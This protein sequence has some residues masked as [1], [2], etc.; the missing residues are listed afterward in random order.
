MAASATLRHRPP[1]PQKA[2]SIA[3]DPS[4]TPEAAL[5]RVVAACLAQLEANTPGARMP[6]ASDALDTPDTTGLAFRA[7]RAGNPDNAEYV[8]QMRVAVRRLRS[9]LRFFDV[10]AARSARK[11]FGATLRRLARTLGEQRNWDVFISTLLPRCGLPP[12]S[13]DVARRRALQLRGTAHERVC[14]RIKAPAHARLLHGLALWLSSLA[15]EQGAGGEGSTA[16]LRTPA[17]QPG[18]LAQVARKG[19]ARLQRRVQRGAK[20]FLTMP[21][22]ARHAVRIEVKRLR[23]AVDAT[24]ALF[25]ARAVKRYTAA[26][27]A[28]QQLLGDLTD[29]N[30]ARMMLRNLGLDEAALAGAQDGLR[31]R[32]VALLMAAPQRFAKV[33]AAAGFWKR[34][35]LRQQSQLRQQRQEGQHGKHREHSK[36]Q[37]HS[38][39]PNQP[40]KGGHHV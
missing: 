12:A 11:R 26:L 35:Q 2:V 36:H 33:Q 4:L 24:G 9:A 10:P 31:T 30:M 34:G 6:C 27:T 22:K 32:E 15:P 38:K 20:H 1:P 23:Y 40:K 25:D 14:D 28:L 16:L 37:T 39:Q 17:V 5:R 29:I 7:H 8:H 13:R 3:L 19:L 18:A 21:N